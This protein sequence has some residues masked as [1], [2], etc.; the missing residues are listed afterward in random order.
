MLSLTHSQIR[1]AL[2]LLVGFHILI[3]CASNY[4]VQLPF[5]LFGWH[6]TWGAF[7]FPFVY[8]ATDLTVR[9]F[10]QESARRIIFKAMV[11]AL[12]V[13]YVIG[14]LFHQGALQGMDALAEYNSFV[15]RIALA[16]FAAYL[17]GQ[18]LDI[19]VFAKLRA[20]KQWWVAPTAS[21]L[22]GNLLDTLVFFSFA[23]YAS[24]DVFMAEN[25]PEIAMVDYG[26]KLLVSI[27]LFLPAYGVLL[28]TLEKRIISVPNNESS[29]A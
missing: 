2:T 3:I 25:W 16:S 7:S 5:T 21:T 22:L 11:P 29:I 19:K 27:C 1:R 10:G 12:V 15:L 28:K 26:F 20:T 8:L 4:L 23:F 9:I 18:L 17:F 13:S 24:T 14:V 6:T